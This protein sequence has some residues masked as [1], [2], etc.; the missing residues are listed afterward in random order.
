MLCWWCPTSLGS[1]LNEIKHQ[2]LYLGLCL[3]I[4]LSLFIFI[5]EY[6]FDYSLESAINYITFL[7]HID[8]NE[9]SVNTH[10]QV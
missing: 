2:L 5:M 10:T 9:C 6:L 1:F 7:L 4:T 3:S 8:F